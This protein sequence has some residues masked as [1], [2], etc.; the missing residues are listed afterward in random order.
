MVNYLRGKDFLRVP[1]ASP[2]RVRAVVGRTSTPPP[3]RRASTHSLAVRRPDTYSAWR[4]EVQHA[5]PRGS[6]FTE[7][8]SAL[9]AALSSALNARFLPTLVSAHCTQ[10]SARARARTRTTRMRSESSNWALVTVGAG[11][12][13]RVHWRGGDGLGTHG[14][15]A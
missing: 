12:C 4:N 15:Y 9:Q 7:T 14:Y 11:H 1:F 6:D 8:R 5:L 2:A 13:K 3:L 10:S